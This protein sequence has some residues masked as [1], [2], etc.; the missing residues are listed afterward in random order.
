MGLSPTELNKVDKLK[1][2]FQSGNTN[3][4][5]EAVAPRTLAP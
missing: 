4:A 2:N 3:D 5:P 1:I